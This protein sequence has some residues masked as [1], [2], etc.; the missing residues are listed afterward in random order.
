MVQPLA[1]TSRIRVYPEQIPRVRRRVSLR[2]SCLYNFRCLAVPDIDPIAGIG[3]SMIAD[4][5]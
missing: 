4:G 2:Y 3:K 5:V 1:Q